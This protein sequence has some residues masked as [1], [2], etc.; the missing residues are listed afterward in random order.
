VKLQPGC[1]AVVG[2]ELTKGS[3]ALALAGNDLIQMSILV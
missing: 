1:C 3:S 2:K